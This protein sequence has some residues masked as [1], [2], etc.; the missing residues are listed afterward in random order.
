MGFQGI[1]GGGP[2]ALACAALLPAEQLKAVAVV[3]G[4][5]SPDMSKLGMRWSNWAGFTV[6]WRYLPG[7]SARYLSREAPARLDLN[8]EERL[9][10]MYE[11]FFASKPPKKDVAAFEDTS[12]PRL[13]LASG[14]E[15]WRQGTTAVQRDGKLLCLPWGFHLE[16]IRRDL[17]IHLWYGKLDQNVPPIHGEQIAAHLG[18]ATQLRIEDETHLS[19]TVNWVW[20]ENVVLKQLAEV[21]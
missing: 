18:P 20:K 17:P 21:L 13:V 2:Y 3:C 1:S 12:I 10:L 5:G 6:G 15:S 14:K 9:Q 16:D 7:L 19:I 8:D 4:M 11:Q